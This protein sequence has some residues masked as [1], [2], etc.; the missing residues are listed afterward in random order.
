MSEPTGY[1]GASVPRSNARRLVEGR[2]RY[3][4]DLRVAGLA[5]IAFFRSPYAHARITRLDTMAVE[6]QPGVLGILTGAECANY[7]TP[8]VA[9][10]EHLSGMKSAKQYPLAINRAT[11]QGEPILGVAAESRAQAEDALDFLEVEWDELPVVADMET[12][13]EPQT[14]VIHPE[15]GDNLCFRRVIDTGNVDA[16]FAT[17]EMV[18]EETFHFGRHTGVPLEPRVILANFDPSTRALTVHHSGQALHMMKHVFAKHL[19]LN[20][21]DVRFIAGDTGGAF[22]IK[23]HVYGDEV[24]TAIMSMKLGRPVKFLADRLESFVSDIHARDHRVKARIAVKHDGTIAGF[25]VDDLTGIGPYSV[26]PRSSGVE[27]N[28]VVNMI[29]APYAHTDYHAELNVVFQ[30]KAPTSQ[31]RAVGHPIACA[32]TEVLVDRAAAALGIDPVE[33]R[34]K[35]Y[36]PDDAYPYTAR[37]GMKFERLSH[38][39]SLDKLVTIMDYPRLRAEQ[40]RLRERGVQRGIGF[41]AL[42]EITNPSAAFYGIGGAP[43][44]SQDGCTMRLDTGGG[45]VCAA[46]VAEIGQGVETAL[47]QIAAQTLGVPIESVRLVTGDTERTPYGGGTW[48]SRTTGIAGE[49]TLLAARALKANILELASHITQRAAATLDIHTGNV[50]EAASGETLLS[51]AEVARIGYF[52]VDTLPAGY[53]PE[54]IATRHY[55]Q[56][57]YGF[58]FANGVHASYLEIDIETGFLRLLDHWVVEDCGTIVNPQLV[59]EQ[60]RGGVVQGIGG[61]LFEHLMYSPEGQL[62]NG[63]LVDYLLPMAGEMPDIHVGH[64]STP[65]ASSQL[66]AKG[67]GEAGTTG[68]PAAILNAVNDALLP[69][70]AHVTDTPV[71]P[72]LLLNAL[73]AAHVPIAVS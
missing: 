38:V 25:D 7:C 70:G 20:E 15:L 62:L 18:I 57:D 6:A 13:L 5:H 50:I 14:P 73:R 41:A 23:L 55:S 43:I 61:A 2:G 69:F 65:T 40:R 33:M 39:A 34:R 71:T 22:G 54:L 30:N 28:Q 47:A 12:A 19:G 24:A 72:E 44:S 21:V 37:S 36:V 60:M 64:V 35:N 11:W 17:A 56:K 3:V 9:V 42:V 26:H 52:R 45:I 32:V 63:S 31:Y 27:G 51:L 53:H 66:G 10:L 46:G 4:D 1:I 68:A 16:A 48:A 49:A 29:G 58:A 8:F 67:A 59:D